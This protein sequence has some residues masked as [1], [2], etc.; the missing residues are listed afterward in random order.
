[1][2]GSFKRFFRGVVKRG[3]GIP[4]S[5]FPLFYPFKPGSQALMLRKP[6]GMPGTG[7]SGR[8]PPQ[9]DW[10]SEKYGTTAE[11]YLASGRRD[12]QEM[13]DILDRAGVAPST[14]GNILEF[15]CGDGRMIRWLEDLARDR[16]I[17][18]VDIDS[19]HIFWCK[20]NL[21]PPFHFLTTTIVPHLP[22]GDGFFGFVYAG[23]VFSHIDDLADAWIAELRRI[24]RPGGCLFITVHLKSDLALLETDYPHSKLTRILRSQPEYEEFKNPDLD[25]IGVGRSARS[26]V[27]YD[28]E[29]LRKIVEPGFKILSIKDKVRL[30]QNGLLLKRV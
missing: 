14:L 1:M 11:E 8:V 29:Y 28:L 6:E 2:A 17:W 24:L 26:F 4:E 19:K 10:I 20:Q 5:D 3:L 16:E 22:F 30:Y 15:G 12:L 21:C 9:K 7:L 27:F 23:S 13:Q 25:L 18:G